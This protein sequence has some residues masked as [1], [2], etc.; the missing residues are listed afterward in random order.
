LNSVVEGKGKRVCVDMSLLLSA[1]VVAVVKGDD[2]EGGAAA[3][4]A[5][6]EVG[7]EEGLFCFRL[8]SLPTHLKTLG[9]MST[10]AEPTSTYL[11]S[12]VTT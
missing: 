7:V 12:S 6:F 2:D 3:A 1:V 8:D 9:S 11:S 10:K 4:A 5:A